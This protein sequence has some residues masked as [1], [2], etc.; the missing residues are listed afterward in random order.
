MQPVSWQACNSY[1]A[2]DEV[3][4]DGG[5]LPPGVVVPALR[6]EHLLGAQ[7]LALE[8][9][10]PEPRAGAVLLP[11]LPLATG[12]LAVLLGYRYSVVFISRQIF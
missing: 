3:M 7:G 4:D 1:L 9:L 6:E 12:S 5:D 11:G 2:E 8:V 10:S